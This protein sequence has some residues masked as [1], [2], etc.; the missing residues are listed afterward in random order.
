LI[1]QIDT[2]GL[3]YLHLIE[4][5]ASGAGQAEVD[6][7]NVPSAAQLF[8]KAWHGVLIA[9]GN[10]RGESAN[11]MIAAGYADAIAFGRLFISNPDLPQRL[12]MNA[13]LTPYNRATFYGGGVEGYLD[14]PVI[15]QQNNLKT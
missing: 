6:H 11:A 14:Y 5:R 3:A 7:Q 13:A 15:D 2:M 1:S 10:F 9:A 12:R 8:R 4:P